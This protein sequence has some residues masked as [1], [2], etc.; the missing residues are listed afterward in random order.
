MSNHLLSS[1]FKA[2]LCR[3]LPDPLCCCVHCADNLKLTF[4]MAVAAGQM[5]WGLHAGSQGY[6][7]APNGGLTL[8]QENLQWVTNYLSLAQ[9]NN[10]GYVVQVSSP[11]HSWL[12]LPVD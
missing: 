9:G 1:C 11:M 8:V 10:S 5:A 7:K 4:P 6:S 2:G 3:F 12:T